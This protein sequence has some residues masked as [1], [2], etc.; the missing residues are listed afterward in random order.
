MAT[1]KPATTNK[2][3]GKSDKDKFTWKKGDVT[4][5]DSIDAFRKAGKSNT[6]RKSK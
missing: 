2:N 3:N 6:K 4:I 5:Y 1:R